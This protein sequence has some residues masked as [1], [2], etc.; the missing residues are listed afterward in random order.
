MCLAT[1]NQVL[2]QETRD[3]VKIYFR[4]AYS[5]LDLSIRN[6][7]EALDRI[8][9]SLEGSYAD[10]IYQLKKIHVIGGASPEG[11]IPL[12]IRLSEKRADR[13]FDYLSKYGSLPDSLKIVSHL[14]RDWQGLLRLVEADPKVPYREETIEFIQDIISRCAHGEREIDNNVGRLSR[15]KGGEPYRYMYH[16]L[17]LFLISEFKRYKKRLPP[18]AVATLFQFYSL[19]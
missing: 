19:Y 9:D 18:W 7:R 10:S 16:Y 2:A 3:S 5:T 17:F 14:G 6:N 15:F 4:Q 13:L 8:A 11:S 12:N 1:W